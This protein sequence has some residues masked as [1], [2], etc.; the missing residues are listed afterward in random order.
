MLVGRTESQVKNRYETLSRR[1]F[2]VTDDDGDVEDDDNSTILGTRQVRF[3][4]CSSETLLTQSSNTSSFL[5]CKDIETEKSNKSRLSDHKTFNYE[6]DQ[7]SNLTTISNSHS[8]NEICYS[9]D[10]YYQDHSYNHSG[11]LKQV[12]EVPYLFYDDKHPAFPRKS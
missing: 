2:S 7:Y 11:Y 6:K 1:S 5:N 10:F 4:N 8:F 9:E 3:F 12:P